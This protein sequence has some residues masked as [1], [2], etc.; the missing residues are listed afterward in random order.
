M[1]YRFLSILLLLPF[2]IQL[3]ASVNPFSVEAKPTIE[4][5]LEALNS[6]HADQVLNMEQFANMSTKEYQKRFGKLKLK[7]RLGHKVYKF[8]IKKGIQNG[9]IEP[10]APAPALGD[11]IDNGFLI[12]FLLGFLLSGMGILIA[13]VWQRTG[14]EEEGMDKL[15]KGSIIGFLASLALVAIF[16]VVYLFIFFSFI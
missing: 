1:I 15:I 3:N 12:G 10:H 5:E 16:Y 13:V 8:H 7:E 9:T 2:S 6:N 14:G 4:N 11:M